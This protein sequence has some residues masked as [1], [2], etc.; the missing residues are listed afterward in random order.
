MDC[1]LSCYRNHSNENRLRK[2]DAC[3]STLGNAENLEILPHHT[4]G[5]T[6]NSTRGT[7]HTCESRLPTI[8]HGACFSPISVAYCERILN[9][10]Y[11]VWK[12]YSHFDG[13]D[14]L[15]PCDWESMILI[16]LL[17]AAVKHISGQFTSLSS[18]VGGNSSCSLT[19]GNLLFDLSSIAV[20]GTTQVVYTVSYTTRIPACGNTP[21]NVGSSVWA[22]GDSWQGGNNLGKYQANWTYGLYN[23][24]NAFTTQYIGGGTWCAAAGINRW[25]T[26]YL[27]CDQSYSYSSPSI[28]GSE[29]TTCHC[30]YFEKV[31]PLWL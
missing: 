4:A 9:W 22:N 13:L 29:P 7:M 16:I 1:W 8:S 28:V 31:F 17:L 24:A 23:G 2:S 14:R 5:N 26:L 18:C 25:A 15:E 11:A 6:F 10:C 30:K 27:I 3:I 19:C 12:Y 21:S 20:S